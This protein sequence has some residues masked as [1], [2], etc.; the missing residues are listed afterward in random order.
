MQ[1]APCSES[2]HYS[3]LQ[4]MILVQIK[5]PEYVILELPK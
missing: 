1:W 5:E 2:Q 3:L 4:L